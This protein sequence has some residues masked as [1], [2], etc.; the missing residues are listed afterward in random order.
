VDAIVNIVE[1]QNTRRLSPDAAQ[2]VGLVETL[3]A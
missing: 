1:I 3:L 2:E